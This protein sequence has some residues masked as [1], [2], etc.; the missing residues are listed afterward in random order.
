MTKIG[1]LSI[2]AFVPEQ[3]LTNQDLEKMVD[4]TDDWIVQRT[5]IRE[6]RIAPKDMH[7]SDMAL[8]A[9]RNCLRDTDITP[10]L[11]VASSG[12]SEKSCPYQASIVANRLKLKKPA[13]FD[14]NATCS[15]LVYGLAVASSMMAA[16]QYQ[17]GLVT[18]SEKMSLFTNYRDRRSCILFGD[19][20][21][22]ILLSKEN[23]EHELLAVELGSD[24]EGFEFV[25]MG[26]REGD[27]YFWQDGQKIFRF[28]VNTISRLIDALKVKA[29]L[30][31]QDHFYIVPHQAN[32]R[33]AQAVAD[34]KNIPM[35]RFIMNIEKYGNTSSASIGL[36]L[37]EAW[38]N[39]RFKKGDTIFLIG[40]GGGLSW[41][42]AAI[43]W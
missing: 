39:N 38:R 26:A 22:A 33:I 23:W 3:K 14:I 35:D 17:Y 7:A 16:A 25:T 9:A 10:D 31:E 11:F 29:G 37:E 15:G 42:G 34:R 1:L 12:T 18:A 4:T 41:A 2:G 43:R 20:A 13:C 32:L 6:R 28:A 30:E 19:G 40:F 24:P 27:P 5:G 36:A 8:E 21:A